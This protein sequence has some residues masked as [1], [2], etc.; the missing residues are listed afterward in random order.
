MDGKAALAEG[1]VAGSLEETPGRL[2]GRRV[3]RQPALGALLRGG[4]PWGPF[5]LPSVIPSAGTSQEHLGPCRGQLDLRSEPHTT[6]LATVL[7]VGLERGLGWRTWVRRPLCLGDLAASHWGFA[8][9]WS[10]RGG[11][12][13]DGHC[14]LLGP[15]LSQ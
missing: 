4:A 8:G 1:T 13:T 11:E 2:G 10:F 6:P 3:G 12:S 7:R 15:L 14:V 5:T 9:W